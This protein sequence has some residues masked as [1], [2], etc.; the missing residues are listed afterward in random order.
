M[1]KIGEMR[2]C[3]DDYRPQEFNESID[4]TFGIWGNENTDVM[5]I[6]YYHDFCKRFALTMGFAENV[7]NQWFGNY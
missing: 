7:V 5:P 1:D 3:L 6:E 4:C 2:F